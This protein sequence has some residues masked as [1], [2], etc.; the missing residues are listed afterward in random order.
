MIKVNSNIMDRNWVH[1]M[2]G[3]KGPDKA[4]LT[5]TTIENIQVGDT[6]MLEGILAVNKEFGAGYVYPVIIE[7]AEIK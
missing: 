3:T 4:S 5:F 7:K 1:L 2:D 6:V